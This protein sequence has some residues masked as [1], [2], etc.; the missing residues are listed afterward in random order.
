MNLP[1]VSV[2]AR[3]RKLI[4]DGDTE[5]VVYCES[6]D[7]GSSHQVAARLL[8]LGYSNVTH[9][10]EGQRGWVDAGLALEG[11]PQT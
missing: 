8:Q 11:G 6:A 4:P 2:D 1:P 9:Y 3:A 7:C 10:A 5:V